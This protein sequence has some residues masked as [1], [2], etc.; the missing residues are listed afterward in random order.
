MFDRMT[1]EKAYI[2]AV[3]LSNLALLMYKN[4]VGGVYSVKRNK[5]KMKVIY[6]DYL[7]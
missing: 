5:Y 1:W 7:K 4:V 2:E 6:C 3:D